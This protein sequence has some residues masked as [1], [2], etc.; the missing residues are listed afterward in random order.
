MMSFSKQTDEDFSGSVHARNERKEREMNQNHGRSRR[1]EKKRNVKKLEKQICQLDS[2][3]AEEALNT[4]TGE[5]N[6][7]QLVVYKE[8]RGHLGAL[9]TIG[10]Q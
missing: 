4:F 6:A 5:E 10:A 3:L 9:G 1:K 2:G 7:N 8:P